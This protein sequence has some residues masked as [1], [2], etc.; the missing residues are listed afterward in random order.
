MPDSTTL[1]YQKLAGRG[2]ISG[3]QGL[4]L[5]NDHLLITDGYYKQRYRRLYLKD[6]QALIW[7]PSSGYVP[8]AVMLCIT[9]GALFLGSLTSLHDPIL[10]WFYFC[11]NIP[12]MLMLASHLY[13]AGSVEF[14]L[15][16]SVQTIKL[17][18][19]ASL[20]KARKVEQQITKAVEAIQGSLTDR[21]LVEYHNHTQSIP[22]PGKRPSTS[23]TYPS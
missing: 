4:Y 8:V 22:Q 6:I 13:Q 19:V 14:G 10:P 11:I 1:H 3:N 5:A 9:V 17:D 18:C 16:T 7:C 23:Q 2:S 12:F 15:Q 20:R 21:D